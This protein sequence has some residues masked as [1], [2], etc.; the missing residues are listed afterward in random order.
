MGN[1]AISLAEWITLVK[2]KTD[3]EVC[4]ILSHLNYHRGIHTLCEQPLI[5]VFIFL[6]TRGYEI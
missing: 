5:I 4:G 6:W 2:M 1:W 3:E